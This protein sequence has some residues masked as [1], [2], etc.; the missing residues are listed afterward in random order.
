MSRN[1][2]YVVVLLAT[3]VSTAAHAALVPY[4]VALD[5]PLELNGGTYPWPDTTPGQSFA[6][7]TGTCDTVLQECNATPTIISYLNLVEVAQGEYYQPVI[8]RLYLNLKDETLLQHLGVHTVVNGL[9]EGGFTFFKNGG[10]P[11]G[12]SLSAGT[13]GNYVFDAYVDFD[14]PILPGYNGRTNVE[15]NAY[16]A[17]LL[18]G[19]SE[20]SPEPVTMAARV[21]TKFAGTDEFYTYIGTRYEREPTPSVPE[22]GS[23][24]LLGLGLLGIG[25]IRRVTGK[26]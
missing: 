3:L 10:V 14:F 8:D 1:F 18:V 13:D 6:T 24:A 2:K 9:G 15:F 20:G 12:V 7:V 22:P 19:L 5:T 21:K 23:L 16:V 11:D 25:A 26:A 17:T 4:L